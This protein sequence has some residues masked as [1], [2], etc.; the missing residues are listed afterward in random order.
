M[1]ESQYGELSV[2]DDNYVTYTNADW[3]TGDGTDPVGFANGKSVVDIYGL[4][5]LEWSCIGIPEDLKDKLIFTPATGELYFDNTNNIE[6]T[7]PIKLT[8]K[9]KITHFWADDE[10]TFTVTLR[11]E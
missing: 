11:R 8:I 5:M 1:K 4:K 7:T 9:A 2:S 3:V 6:L 10:V